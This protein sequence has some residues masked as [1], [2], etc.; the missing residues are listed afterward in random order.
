[1]DL[2]NVESLF[3]IEMPTIEESLRKT[4]DLQSGSIGSKKTKSI[5]VTF[6]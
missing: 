2:D 1:M 3:D 4:S 5:G 6:I